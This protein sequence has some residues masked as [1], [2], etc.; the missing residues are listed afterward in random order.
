MEIIP[1]QSHHLEGITSVYNQAIRSTT[2]TFDTV[3][4]SVTEME[5]WLDEHLPSYPVIVSTDGNTVTGWASLSPWSD[6]CAYSS[7]VENSV[8]VLEEYRGKGIGSKLLGELI[9]LAR[10]R[11]FHSIIA[12]ITDGNAH[13]IHLHSKYG[14]RIIGEMKEVGFKFGRRLN[15]TLMQLLLN[16]P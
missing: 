15:V 14:F 8:Y 16:T 13:S 6:R 3:E 12:R 1:A 2:A 4:K 5:E 7:T 11:E 10:E 9:N